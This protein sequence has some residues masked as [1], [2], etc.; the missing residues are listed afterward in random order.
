MWHY[1]KLSNLPLSRKCEF[2]FCTLPVPARGAPFPPWCP[3]RRGPSAPSAGWSACPCQSAPPPGCSGPPRCCGSGSESEMTKATLIEIMARKNINQTVIVQCKSINL[4][5]CQTWTIWKLLISR[6][7][8]VTCDLEGINY[9]KV[10]GV[11]KLSSKEKGKKCKGSVKKNSNPYL[12]QSGFC[13]VNLIIF[14][15]Q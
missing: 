5:I 15:L 8:T 4:R 10:W 2:S 9:W 14:L 12:W 6:F 7:N 13:N 3:S 1:Y 11:A